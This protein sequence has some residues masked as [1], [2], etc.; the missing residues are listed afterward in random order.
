T[1]GLSAAA[2]PYD[3]LFFPDGRLRDDHITAETLR[4]YR[5]IVLPE[6]SYLTEAQAAALHEYLGT[7]GQVIAVGELGTNLDEERR[8]AIAEHPRTIRYATLDDVASP[9]LVDDP[10]VLVDPAIDVGLHVQRLPDG[11][12]IH[13]VNYAYDHEQDKVVPAEGVRLTVRLPLR[14]ATATC[15]VPGQEPRLLEMAVDGTTH[16]FFLEQVPLYTI[17]WLGDEPAG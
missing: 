4:P 17:I 14:Y 2:Q 6:C 7:G 13:L 9:T 8:R 15:Y 3:V 5:A 10:Q 16:A 12:A 11:A 1:R